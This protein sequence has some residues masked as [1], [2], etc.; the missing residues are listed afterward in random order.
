MEKSLEIHTI[1]RIDVLRGTSNVDL[2]GLADLLL[3]HQNNRLDPEPSHTHYED[4]ECPDHPIVDSIV[5]ELMTAFKAA[6]KM[7]LMLHS[8]WAHIHQK[9]MST[10]M[11]DHYPCDVSS[12]FYVSVPEGSGNICFHPSHNKYHPT[13]EVFQPQEGMFLMFPGTLEHSVT[14]NHSEE[15]RISLA[16]NHNS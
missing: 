16:F 5:H 1:S 3:E 9:N 14:R 11:H 2:T 6:T 12:A 10:N 7:D 15:P 4:S 13:R 8:K